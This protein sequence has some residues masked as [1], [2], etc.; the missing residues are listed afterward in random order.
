MDRCIFFSGVVIVGV[1]IVLVCGDIS[2]QSFDVVF[3]VINCGVKCLCMVIIWLVNFLGLGMVVNNV[4]V[5]VNVVLGGMLDICVY[6]VGEIVSVFEVFDVVFE[7][8]VDMYYGVEYYWQGKLLVFNFFIVVLLGMIVIEIMGWVEFGGGQEFWDE[9]F[10]QFNI[11]FFQVGNFGYQ[12]GGWFKC[13]INL[14]EDFCGLCMCILGL[15]GNVLCELGGVVVM[16]FGGEIYFVFQFGV[17]DVIEW[18]GFWNDLVFGFYCE[19]F[20]YYGL[21]FY[22]LG[23]C[24]GVGMN[25]GVWNDFDEDYKVIIQVVCCV[26]NNVLLVEFIYQN[27]QVFD[28]LFNE[29]GVQLCFFIDEMWS[30]IG[31]I[32]EQVVFDIGNV[33]VMM[34]CVYESYLIVCNQMQ[35]WG[36]ILEMLYMV[37]CDCVLC[38]QIMWQGDG[39]F[40]VLVLVG[41]GLSIVDGM[42]GGGVVGWFQVNLLGIVQS[43]GGK[44]VLVV[45]YFWFIL[46]LFLI[47]VVFGCFIVLLSVWYGFQCSFIS[48]IE[49]VIGMFGGVV[50]W[51]VLGLVVV[52]VIIVVQC[53]VFGFVFIK[54]QESV[55][56]MYGLFFLFVLVL[57]LFVDGYVCVDIFYFKVSECGK[58]WID[59]LGVY[60]ILILM[61]VFILWVLMGYM[62]FIWC[63][64]ECL[65][66]SDGLFFV[67]L[68]KIVILLFVVL[69]ILQ[70]IVM[71]VCFGFKLVGQNMLLC[72]KNFGEGEV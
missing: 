49:N 2:Q 17:I 36:W 50:C 26:V 22:E 46:I 13:E 15:G 6:V 52:I 54:L 62:N 18:V 55:I 8:M 53:Y 69:M 11:K 7:G 3:L 56:Y 61:S 30:W 20:F 31:E 32:F 58:V 65:W 37:Y 35:N 9:L 42:I 25:L 5:Y 33:D 41:I 67:F 68:F 12:M 64:F 14:L 38:G 4:V 23:F 48:F 47:M 10:G 63:I 39:F 29:Y 72:L 34:C 28:V 19:V 21:G 57:I 45:C 43:I 70:G 24:F 71:V 51:F 27:V 44:L 59:L 16:F 66:E 1:F 60:L 40:F